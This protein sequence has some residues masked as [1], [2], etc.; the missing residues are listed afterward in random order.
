MP[1]YQGGLSRAM[2]AWYKK[3][4]EATKT[5]VFDADAN[6]LL[7]TA[8]TIDSLNHI[9]HRCLNAI[10]HGA[11]TLQTDLIQ[12]QTIWVKRYVEEA[13]RSYK[14]MSAIECQNWLDKTASHPT[15]LQ[16]SIVERL[17][18]IRELVE[19]Q[20]HSCRIEGLLTMYDKLSESEKQTFK[21]LLLTR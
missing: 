8:G 6:A 20:L 18:K 16:A 13:E 19:S 1:G 3:L 15:Y 14:G 10:K 21:K 5:H 4:P 17:I 7:T 11:N 2:I 9:Q 12:K